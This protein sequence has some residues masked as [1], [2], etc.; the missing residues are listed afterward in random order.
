MA[1]NVRLVMYNARAIRYSAGARSLCEEVG[2][3]IA[4]RANA[5]LP[6]GTG[7]GFVMDS[8]AGQR[9]PWGRW[10]VSVTAVGR[11]ARNHNARHNTLHKATFG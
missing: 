6:A 8:K 4:A 10:R 1:R 5:A 11:Y 3:G 7:R 9:K 2:S